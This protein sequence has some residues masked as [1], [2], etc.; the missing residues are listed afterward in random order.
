MA[1]L[2]AFAISLLTTPLAKKLALKVGAIDM[3]GKAGTASARHL[4]AAPTPRMGG[5]A[6]FLGFFFS[7]L[8]FAPL[9]SKNVS[10]L[11][12]A[13][14]IV[15]LGALDDI[16]D[17]PARYK[18]VVQFAAAA[19]AVAGGNQI[20]FFS[21]LMALDGGRWQLGA[22]SIPAT[23]LWIVLITNAVNLID[24][25]DGLAAGVSTISCVSLVIIA[26]VYSNPGVAILTSALAGGCIGFLPYNRP[27]AKIF[28]GDTGS[29][30]LGYVMAVA[31]IQGLFKF[32][33]IISFV[34]P[35]FMLGVPI[36][37]TCFAVIRRL[38]NG[39]SPFKADREH[40]HYRLM[41]MGFSKK[42]TVAVL[43]GISAIL[44][45]TAVVTTASGLSR[46]L[47][48]LVVLGLAVIVMFKGLTRRE[49]EQMEDAP[50][51]EDE[52]ADP[53][54]RNGPPSATAP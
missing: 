28:M 43:Y 45:L 4:H 34:I 46:G 38:R 47:I 54:R 39:E 29:T 25:L 50:E 1:L 33:A 52:P 31:S 44:G 17:I 23:L 24:G 2:V 37:D 9:G 14:V 32:Y 7:V 19:V 15:L 16:Y 20:N 10:M 41:D 22:L 21:R 18:L 49:A 53:E 30:L 5:L 6:I 35:F 40:V 13:V 42:Q 12:G 48:L 26:L 3:P 36:F 51:P 27:P 11:I 8:L